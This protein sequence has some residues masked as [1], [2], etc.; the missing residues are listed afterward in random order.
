MRSFFRFRAW[1][2]RFFASVKRTTSIKSLLT[3]IMVRTRGEAESDATFQDSG[4]TACGT[5][6]ELL[7]KTFL[8]VSLKLSRS[9]SLRGATLRSP[10]FCAPW[11]KKDLVYPTQTSSSWDEWTHSQLHKR[12]CIRAREI[13]GAHLCKLLKFDSSRT[14]VEL[15]I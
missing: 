6:G 4:R 10:F 8:A 2:L 15:V 13:V 1:Y 12:R 9:G 5:L 14:L 7:R 3:V 11:R